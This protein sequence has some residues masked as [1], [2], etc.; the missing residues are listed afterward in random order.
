M[1]SLEHTSSD[2][3]PFAI[4]YDLDT[5][6]SRNEANVP[7]NGVDFAIIPRPPSTELNSKMTF[8]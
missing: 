8:R 3:V 5:E 7:Q 6:Q 1:L 4:D 2:V